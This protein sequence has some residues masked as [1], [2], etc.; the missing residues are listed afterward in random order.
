AKNIVNAGSHLALAEFDTTTAKGR[1]YAKN[2]RL[3]TSSLSATFTV[4]KLTL[5]IQLGDGGESNKITH[6]SSTS[7]WWTNVFK[8]PTKGAAEFLAE[9][10]AEVQAWIDKMVVSALSSDTATPT[11]STLDV[12]GDVDLLCRTY[13]DQNDFEYN[14]R[15]RTPEGLDVTDSI[16]YRI[17]DSVTIVADEIIYELIT[18]IEVMYREAKGTSGATGYNLNELNCLSVKNPRTYSIDNYRINGNVASTSDRMT[19]AGDYVLNFDITS[20]NRTTRSVEVHVTIL[21][22]SSYMIFTKDL[23]KVYD[24]APV[25]ALTLVD[26]NLSGFNGSKSDLVCTYYEIDDKGLETIMSGA[27]TNVGNYRVHIV[28]SADTDPSV[29]KNY[30]TLEINRTFSIT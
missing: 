19:D 16:E 1:D 18:P 27:P 13:S 8:T 4:T 15:I 11:I 5:T 28:S 9:G 10:D 6:Y 21:Q 25:D 12:G 3:Q 2:Y 29:H 7:P 20:P 23:T 30:T 14:I 22:R 26:M 24:A 17:K